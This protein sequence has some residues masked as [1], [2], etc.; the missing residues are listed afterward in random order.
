VLQCVAMCCVQV[1]AACVAVLQCVAVRHG[2]ESLQIPLNRS[3]AVYVLQCIAVYCSVFSVLQCV[4][5]R[6]GGRICEV[7]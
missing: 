6:Y 1:V 2:L 7:P 4:A 5:V 3:A